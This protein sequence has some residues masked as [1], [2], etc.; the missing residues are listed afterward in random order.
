[1]LGEDFVLALASLE[2]C[3]QLSSCCCSV[4]L[5]NSSRVMFSLL[6]GLSHDAVVASRLATTDILTH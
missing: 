1:M 2:A 3:V 5:K 6:I 4:E